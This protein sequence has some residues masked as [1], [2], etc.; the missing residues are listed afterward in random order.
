MEKY[1]L[2][3]Y[4]KN[5]QLQFFFCYTYIIH[6]YILTELNI[7]EYIFNLDNIVLFFIKYILFVLLINFI[8]LLLFISIIFIQ[9]FY[10]NNIAC[11]NH[12]T[13]TNKR[14]F[15]N[16]L[17]SSSIADLKDRIYEEFCKTGK[18]EIGSDHSTISS[19][20]LINET[21]DNSY[22]N[23]DYNNYINFNNINEEKNNDIV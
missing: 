11:L 17:E 15:S 10:N 19:N 7:S 18:F 6:N 23:M 12:F 3:F 5:L 4:K 1:L 16:V 8:I 13:H 2:Y 21:N 20:S 22:N 14:R 9:I